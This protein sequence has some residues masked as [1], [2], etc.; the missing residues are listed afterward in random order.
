M[1]IS[2]FVT[3]FAL[4]STIQ[5]KTDTE[6]WI[7][8][9]GNHIYST[10]WVTTL[11]E[12]SLNSKRIAFWRERKTKSDFFCTFHFWLIVI[13]NVVRIADDFHVSFTNPSVH[14]CIFGCRCRPIQDGRVPRSAFF[15]T[16][17]SRLFWK[18]PKRVME[19]KEYIF[20]TKTIH[21]WYGMKLSWKNVF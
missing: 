6:E 3:T 15:R 16:F 4:L 14:V 8:Q 13:C 20:A 12:K 18:V 1:I 2:N 9:I 21:F 19:N 10:F 5:R 11:T 7:I 17:N